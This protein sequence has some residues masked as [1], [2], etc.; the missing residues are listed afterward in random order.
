[1]RF[2]FQDVPET[3]AAHRAGFYQG[4]PIN[5]QP[6]SPPPEISKPLTSSFYLQCRLIKMVSKRL[7]T[8]SLSMQ[9][10]AKSSLENW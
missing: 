4:C 10:S 2:Q 6:A 9:S 5:F 3:G 7:R 1:M 8:E